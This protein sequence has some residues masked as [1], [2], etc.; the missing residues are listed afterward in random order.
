M[1][2]KETHHQRALQ[3][4]WR[5]FTFPVEVWYGRGHRSSVH[6]FLKPPLSLG[7]PDRKWALYYLAEEAEQ[8][9][10]WLWLRGEKREWRKEGS[11]TWS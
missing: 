11:Q 4:G 8:G 6:R 1:S 3:V 10:F 7:A 2:G 9:S 5:A